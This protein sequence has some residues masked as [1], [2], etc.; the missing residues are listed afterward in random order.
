MNTL[1]TN[2]PLKNWKPVSLA[3]FGMSAIGLVCA[4]VII[5][6]L[7]PP[8]LDGRTPDVSIMEM[9]IETTVAILFL[10]GGFAMMVIGADPFEENSSGLS[11]DTPL[12]D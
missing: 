12:E 5:G 3:G 11:Q 9:A 8:I 4:A 2:S 7:M 6:Q 1:K 10:M